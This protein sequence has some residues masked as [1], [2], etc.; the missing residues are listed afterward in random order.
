M[1]VVGEQAG[2]L[3]HPH[4]RRIFSLAEPLRLAQSAICIIAINRLASVP[5]GIECSD[6]AT[7][8]TGIRMSREFDKRAA[9]SVQ[10]L[11]VTD[12]AAPPVA[13]ECELGVR[14]QLIQ[15]SAVTEVANT[16]DVANAK[17]KRD[18]SAYMREFMRKRRAAERK[19]AR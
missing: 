11:P 13:N 16:A 6:I 9:V 7:L 1:R 15:A 10:S 2:A 14:K 3:A 8:V 17:P 12:D 18:R 5:R 19:A 4:S